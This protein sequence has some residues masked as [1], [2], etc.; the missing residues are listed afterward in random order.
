MRGAIGLCIVNSRYGTDGMGG[1]NS[2]IDDAENVQ[3]DQYEY[4]ENNKDSSRNM[5]GM[6]DTYQKLLRYSAVNNYNCTSFPRSAAELLVSTNSQ[7]LSDY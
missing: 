4:Y 7:L 1:G 3:D 5:Y 6:K 2:D